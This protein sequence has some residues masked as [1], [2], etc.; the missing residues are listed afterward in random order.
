M[1]LLVSALNLFIIPASAAAP[2]VTTND[3]TSVEETTATFNGLILGSN[4]TEYGFQYGTTVSYGSTYTTQPSIIEDTGGTYNFIVTG[5]FAT[6][7]LAEKL[8]SFSGKPISVQYQIKKYGS[9]TGNVYA[10]VYWVSNG[11]LA[12][13]SGALDISTLTTSYQWKTFTYLTPIEISADDVYVSIDYSGG[14]ISKYLHVY[15]TG[16]GQMYH[17]Q[18]ST[19]TWLTDAHSMTWRFYY[20]ATNQT[21]TYVASLT[22]GTLYHY[23]A[24]ATNG[25]G[26]GYGSDKTFFT[27]PNAPTGLTVTN[28]ASGQQTLTWT[29]GTGYNQSVV[30]GTIGSYPATPQSG[31]DVYNSTGN[32]VVRNGLSGGDDWYYRVW[33]YTVWGSEFKFSDTYTQGHLIAVVPPTVTTNATTGVEE[34]NATLRGY[35]NNN[36]GE[37]C[38]VGFEYGTTTGYGINIED[39]TYIYAGGGTTWKV[40]QYWKSNMTKKAETAS[41]GGGIRSITQD[42]TYVYA[43]GETTFKVYQYWKSNM[44][45]KAETASYGGIIF[46]IAQ[47]DTYVYAGGTTTIKVYQYW[48][49]N[50][51]KKAETASYGGGIYGIAT[52]NNYVYAGGSTTNKVYQYWKSNMT[53]KAETASHGGSISAIA[54]DTNY[55][56][57]GGGTIYTIS[58]YWK[59][60]MTKKADTASYG[61]VVSVIAQDNTYVYAGGGTT[62]KVYQYWK[63]NMTKK[64]ETANYGGAIYGIATDNNYVYAGGSTTQTV[65]QYWKSN[66]TKKAETAS[67]GGTI[68]GLLSESIYY[69]TGQAFN[70]NILGLTPGQKYHYRSVATNSIGTSYGSDLT[71]FTKPNAPTGLTVTN[72]ASGQQTLTWTH[73]T[74][75]NQSVVRGTIGSYPATP[76]SGVD[77]YNSTGNSVV[78]NGLT[79]GDD[80]YYRVWEY[81]VWGSEFQF[82]DLNS[83][84]HLLV[85]TTPSV[86]GNLASL[87][88]ETTAQL[89]GNLVD[90][91]GES[92][93]VRFQYGLTTGYGTNTTNQIVGV[94]VF[95]QAIASLTQG[96][97]YHYRAY[98]NN[99]LFSS[100]SGD[101]TFLTKPNDPSGLNAV[102]IS[103]TRIDLTW[104]K[105][106]GADYTRIQRDTAG[107]PATISSG[108]NV[109][110]GTGSSYSNIGLTEGQI[111]YYRAWSFASDVGWNQ[112]SDSHSSDVELTYPD[113]PTSTGIV[114]LNATHIGLTWTNGTGADR[115]VILRKTTGMPS[116]YTDGTVVYNGT[117]S[118]YNDTLIPGIALYY[119]AWSYAEDAPLHKYSINGTEF[120]SSTGLAL[121][122]FSEDDCSGL[123]GY[124][125][126]VSNQDGSHVYVLN[127]ITGGIGI[128]A[129]LCPQGLVS[130]LVSCNGYRSRVYYLT[131]SSG[132]FFYLNAYLPLNT[133]SELYMITVVGDKNEYGNS[134]PL[135]HVA[136]TVKTYINCTGQYETVTNL[137]TDAYGQCDMYLR[138][139]LYKVTLQKTGYT[140]TSEDYIPNVDLRTRTFR[141]SISAVAPE[142]NDYLFRNITYSITPKGQV[143]YGSFTIV[144]TIA[145]SDNQL[146]WFSLEVT[147][148]NVTSKLWDQIYFSNQ[149]N[150]SGGTISYTVANVTGRY[151]AEFW[152]KKIGFDAYKMTEIGSIQ[153]S[154]EKVKQ[155]LVSIPDYAYFIA[156]LVIMALVMGFAMPYA[157]IGTGYIGLIIM[158]IALLLKPVSIA[159]GHAPGDVVSGWWIFGVTFLMYTVGIFLWSRL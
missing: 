14:T 108:V 92:C 17:F 39:E 2:T 139:T 80:W 142:D 66:M 138:S 68:Y 57:A 90:T 120:A 110:N 95:I 62:W 65:N 157:G 29:H 12:M 19:S 36:G 129:S 9:P 73:G 94:G 11:T 24:F 99:S 42:S 15:T 56:Y 98:A 102:A 5:A 10:S 86:S 83:S 156:V 128:N 27:K 133:T 135:D 97:L 67:Y 150:A 131:I 74:G 125:I 22:P 50:M 38:S 71:F 104:S 3:A 72:T 53:K 6:T 127:N 7:R 40:Y 49:S 114:L 111:Y 122:A 117:A 45:K 109:Y 28:T 1:L 101:V 115:T 26:N 37:N 63:S 107:Y 46:V 82:S 33:E 158:A 58:Q 149:T 136:V 151:A 144:Y 103:S 13:Q 21:T 137:Y 55:I 76:Q 31:V 116:S 77:V 154:I 91:G 30:R 146:E 152:F 20:Y 88:E 34:T 93:T 60:N 119:K 113:A 44:T 121:E 153:Y 52:D 118:Y 48:K 112:W 70:N 25:D 96:T 41:Y 32:S 75:Y 85:L 147:K 100:V 16:S 145:S 89:N 126:L 159:V 69:T 130:I 105:G 18:S 64:A 123:V 134:P 81:T 54:E 8:L 140:T 141:L 23:R 43:G 61:G 155:A 132:I 4:I 51:T 143:H 78:R 79:G 106:T 84:N 47:D 87:V 59:S 35:L 148:Y 124:N